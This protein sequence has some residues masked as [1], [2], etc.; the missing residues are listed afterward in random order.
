MRA[1]SCAYI[2]IHTCARIILHHPIPFYN[3]TPHY[4]ILY[5]T[6]NACVDY[7]PLTK[8]VQKI[9]KKLAQIFGQFIK[10]Q[11]LCSRFRAKRK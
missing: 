5:H 4:T 11:Y 6:K 10:K 3:T 1:R 2:I 8:K 7:Q 9:L